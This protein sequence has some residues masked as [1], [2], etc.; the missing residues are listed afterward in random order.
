MLHIEP[1]A[2]LRERS[3]T[4]IAPGP[5][6]EN[7][8]ENM[9]PRFDGLLEVASNAQPPLLIVD[10]RHTKLIGSAFLGFLLRLSNRVL[11]REGGRFGVCHLAPFCR[12]VCETTRMD[13]V[14]ELFETRE[15]ALEA[16]AER[17]AS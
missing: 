4:V 14:W 13:K 16:L 12:T 3:V 6:Y 17:E 9:L 10:L 15:E 7:I 11:G 8:Y 2:V 1:P 5:E